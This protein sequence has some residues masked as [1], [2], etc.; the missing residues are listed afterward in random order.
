MAR[1]EE[2]YERLREFIADASH[3]LRSP[4]SAL[5]GTAS[6][7]LRE[8]PDLVDPTRSRLESISS[9][10]QHMR[11]LVD[12]LLVLAR[13]ER[14]MEH[15]LFIV[16]LDTLFADVRAR[17]RHIADERGIQLEFAGASGIE[18]YG[19]PDQIERIVANLVE[20]ALRYTAC[21]GR[22]TIAWTADPV[23]LQI[24]IE[25]N[26]SG[27]APDDIKRVF[28]RFWRGDA[29]RTPDRGTGLGLAIALALARRHGGDIVAASKLG[30]GS[31]F[32]LTLPRRPPSLH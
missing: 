12:D 30:K 10:T 7:A 13:A 27:I 31:T 4:L 22:V 16:D 23:R 24:A 1:A 14:T 8:A 11:R 32:T 28:D 29:A 5:A 21:G 9:R 17:Y 19:N 2:G 26:G 25:D 6:V 15:E 20:N 3:E 18:V